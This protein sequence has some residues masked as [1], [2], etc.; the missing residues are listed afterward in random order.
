MNTHHKYIHQLAGKTCRL[1]VL[2]VGLLAASRSYAGSN[3]WQQ[4]QADKAAKKISGKVLDAEGRIIAEADITNKRSGES[5]QTNK[6]GVFAIEVITGDELVAQLEGYSTATYTITGKESGAIQLQIREQSLASIKSVQ[7]PTGVRKA[8]QTVGSFDAI[9]NRELIKSPVVDITNALSGRLTGLY[10]LQQ[11][12]TPGSEQAALYLRG[13]TN[14]L[15]VIDGIPRSYTLLNPA[16]IESVTVL[17]DALAANLYGIRA[18]NGALLINTRKG[19]P[20]RQTISFT[21]QYGIQKATVRPSYL[22]SYDYARLFNEALAN[23]GKPALYTE[24]DLAA[25]R[26]GTDPYGHPDVDWQKNL[27]RDQMNFARYSADIS[28]GG[29]FAQYYLALDHVNQQG[30]FVTDNTRTYNTNNDYKQYSIRSNVMMNVNPTLKAFLNVFALVR[31]G[32]QPGNTTSSIF[33][34]FLN[35]PNNAYPILNPNG[36]YAATSERNKNLFGLTVNSGYRQSYNRNLYADVGLQQSLDAV[37]KGLWVRAKASFG[38]DLTET[39]NRSKTF[40]TYKMNVN[41]ATGD[42]TYTKFGTDGTQSNSGSINAQT[43][44]NYW[45]VVVGYDKNLKGGHTVTGKAIVSTQQYG[46]NSDLPLNYNTWALNGAWNYKDRYDVEL[47]A[48]ANKQSLYPSGEEVGVFPAAGIGWTISHESWFPQFKSLNSLR[49]KAS[50]GRV[51]MDDVGYY[52]YN[53][54][55][56]SATGYTLGV[57]PTSISGASESTL[58]NPNVTWEKADKLN[59][60]AEAT[61]FGNKLRATLEYYN[62]T[63]S[64]LMQV[65]GRSLATA[66]FTYPEENIGKN[67]YKGWDLSVQYED[68]IGQV[69]YYAGLKASTRQSE[70]LFMD[71]VDRKYDWMKRT[72]QQVGQVF[73]Y[74]AEGFYSA[75]DV[76]NNVPTMEGYT[77]VAGDIRYKDLNGDKVINRYDITVIGNTKPFITGGFQ[78]GAEYKGISISFLLQGVINRNLIRNAS[79]YEFQT[80]SGGGYTQAQSFHL[81]RWTPETANSATYPRLT[82]GSNANNQTTSTF[83]VDNGNYLRLKNV[84]LAWAIPLKWIRTVKLNGA[85]VFVNG[86]N[87]LT[88]TKVDRLDPENPSGT[89]YPNLKVFNAG[90][91]IKF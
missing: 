87:L 16:E 34:E 6:S 84:E 67:R 64:D 75:A 20:G 28:G 59:I 83:W 36:S 74:V 41:T 86:F 29:K 71:E 50:Y 57:S 47:S 7:L 13:V 19:L 17:K 79:D 35:V 60:G 14:P 5:V 73:G 42:T 69:K 32:T 21:A 63:Y 15:I 61:M 3:G 78:G 18:A 77:P 43:R 26:D 62:D 51:G 81:D 37:T 54:F 76:A 2:A 31:N 85:R 12:A 40:A 56:A 22:N 4:E 91:N 53:Q 70:V 27:L 89:G 30:I 46:S 8:D 10:T 82:V 52:V 65:R 55:Y 48:T 80:L 88:I 25:Y 45:E 58:A 9:Y 33:S 68:N 49:M 39:I 44:N 66:G 11:G 38:T 1:L 72:G 23:D 24:A 90:V